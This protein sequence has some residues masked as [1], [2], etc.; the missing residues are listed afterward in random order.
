VVGF[1]SERVEAGPHGGWGFRVSLNGLRMSRHCF[2]LA[3]FGIG[4]P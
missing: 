1:P 4:E 2:G 3:P